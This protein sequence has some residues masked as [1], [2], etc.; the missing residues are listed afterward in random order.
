M[1]EDI[2]GLNRHPGDHHYRAFVGP[3][4][5][6][7][8]VSAMAFGL[9]TA[10]GLRQHHRLLDIGCGS[11]RLGRLF[12]PYLNQGNYVGLE[13]NK[14][15]VEEGLRYEVG[16]SLVKN[17]SPSFVYGSSLSGWEGKREFDFAVAQS[18]FSHTGAD[19]LLQWLVE[20]ADALSESGVL[21]ATII[22]GAEDCRDS[23]WIYPECVEYRIET[24]SRWAE[25][26]GLQTQVLDW[27][28]PRQTWCAFYKPEF[29]PGVLNGGSPS[30]NHFGS[31]AQP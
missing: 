8:L 24:I 20:T 4:V 31:R 2:L 27:Y 17:R 21:F 3:S 9:L 14:W 10:C 19:L 18:I 6:Y 28:H 11:L 1:S 15:L 29:D 16:D 22:E 25:E 13:P 12:I 30:W 26:N 5:D 7:D 23:G